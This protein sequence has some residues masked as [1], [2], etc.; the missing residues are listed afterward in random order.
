MNP[1]FHLSLDISLSIKI[2]IKFQING[3][4][5]YQ[6]FGSSKGIYMIVSLKRSHG[7]N[8]E[9]VYNKPL[10]PWLSKILKIYDFF[11]I[12]LV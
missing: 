9:N 3:T 5:K 6:Y 4:T 8:V 2:N 11:E 12:L 1:L 10:N 7:V